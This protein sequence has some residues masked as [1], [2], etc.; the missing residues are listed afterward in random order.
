MAKN[1]SFN[2]STEW[3]GADQKLTELK[4]KLHDVEHLIADHIARLN[5]KHNQIQD[6]VNA[7]L[8]NDNKTNVDN[9][10][11]LRSELGALY[12]ERTIL[13]LAIEQQRKAID[14]LES[15]LGR[16]ICERLRPEALKIVRQ[17]FAVMRELSIVNQ[18]ER[19]FFDALRDERIRFTSWLPRF[20]DSM[21]SLEDD[22]SNISLFVKRL[23]EDYPEL[24]SETRRDSLINQIMGAQDSMLQSESREKD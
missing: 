3:R 18:A 11:H 20:N 1:L 19:E 2:R 6:E 23:L 12:H 5:K 8:R 15:Q 24:K 10:D 9:P 7:L 21:G 4:T 13:N 14:E 16:Q 22:Y 17:K